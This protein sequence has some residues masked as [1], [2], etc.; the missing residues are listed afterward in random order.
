MLLFKYVNLF[1]LLSLFSRFST[2]NIQSLKK[3][4]VLFF[5]VSFNFAKGFTSGFLDSKF[6][7]NL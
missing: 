2:V 6:P 5:E 1:F 4:P 3:T 7:K